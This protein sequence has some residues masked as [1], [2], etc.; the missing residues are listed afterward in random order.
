MAVRRSKP[1]TTISSSRDAFD[2]MPPDD[3]VVLDVRHHQFDRDEEPLGA[4]LRVCL[5]CG[6][7]D[8]PAPFAEDPS[9]EACRHGDVAVFAETTPE[10]RAAVDRLVKSQQE[11]A[12]CQRTLDT[13]ARTAARHGEAVIDSIGPTSPVS[14]TASATCARCAESV[15]GDALSDTETEPTPARSKRP[16]RAPRNP[17]VAQTLLDFGLSSPEDRTRDAAE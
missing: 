8:P 15:S 14:T 9:L 6:L 11:I 2:D 12:R 4:P 16:R 7:E 1:V 3:M 13:L 10:L 5:Q 17:S